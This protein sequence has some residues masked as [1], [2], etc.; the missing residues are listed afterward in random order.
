MTYTMDNKK[1]NCSIVSWGK[2]VNNKL[3]N[4]RVKR[5]G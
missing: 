2:D 5:D 4:L 1:E 3:N